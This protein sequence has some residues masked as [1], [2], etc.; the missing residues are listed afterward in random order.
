[1]KKEVLKELAGLY[2]KAT[3]DRDKLEDTAHCLM[4]NDYSSDVVEDI[5]SEIDY[6][7]NCY[8]DIKHSLVRIM[9]LD[10]VYGYNK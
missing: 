4:A 7:I 10:K 3:N 2:A 9:A 8:E 5:D 6:I 1:M